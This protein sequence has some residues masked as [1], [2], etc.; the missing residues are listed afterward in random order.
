MQIADSFNI[1]NWKQIDSKPA[2][3]VKHITFSR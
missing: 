1:Q 3:A 2:V